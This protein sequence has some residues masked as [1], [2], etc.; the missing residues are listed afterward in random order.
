MGAEDDTN[1][2]FRGYGQS[3]GNYHRKTINVQLE[4]SCTIATPVIQVL[5]NTITN[6]CFAQGKFSMIPKA[7][8]SI[9]QWEK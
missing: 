2:I 8:M 3:S 7:A 4:T 9:K 5:G 1:Y 6:P